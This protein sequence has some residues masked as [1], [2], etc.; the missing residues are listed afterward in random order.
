MTMPREIKA[1]DTVRLK[2]DVNNP[3]SPD[4]TV[5][6]T[7][8]TAFEEDEDAVPSAVVVWFNDNGKFKRTIIAFAALALVEDNDED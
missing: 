4:M 1:G 7:V 5:E 2:C 3:H 8:D 6:Q